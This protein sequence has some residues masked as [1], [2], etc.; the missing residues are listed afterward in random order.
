MMPGKRTMAIYAFC[1]IRNFTDTTEALQEEV[2]IFVNEIARIVHGI[3]NEH[4]GMPNKNI[5][6]AF[7]LVWKIPETETY[8]DID[9]NI[10]I[11]DSFIVNNLADIS[12]IAVLKVIAKLNREPKILNYRH[13]A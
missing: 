7:L 4:L 9:R 1:D 6:D 2:M 13:L 11:A 12:L 5:G 3:V 10:S 8:E